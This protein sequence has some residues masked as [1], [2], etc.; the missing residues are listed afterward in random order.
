MVEYKVYLKKSGSFGSMDKL[1][2]VVKIQAENEKEL[3]SQLKN[4][5]KKGWKIFKV[6]KVT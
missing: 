2:D 3:E 6:D 1:W 5:T 4:L